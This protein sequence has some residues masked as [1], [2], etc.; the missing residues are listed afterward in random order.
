MI[1]KLLG[2][3][4]VQA[5]AGFAHLARESATASPARIADNIGADILTKDVAANSL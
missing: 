5:T 3:T 4:Q 2:H 1:G